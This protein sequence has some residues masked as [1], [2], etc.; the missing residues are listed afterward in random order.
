[1]FTLNWSHIFI[2][3]VAVILLYILTVFGV[4][5][6]TRRRQI[7]RIYKKSKPTKWHDY[8]DN[9]KTD[10]VKE[11]DYKL[12]KIKRN[13]KIHYVYKHNYNIS[14]DEIPDEAIEYEDDKIVGLMNP[15][16]FFTNL[17]FKQKAW[18]QNLL[19]NNNDKKIGYHETMY[20]HSI[21]DKSNQQGINK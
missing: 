12:V 13:N 18:L 1:M 15:F 6:I 21:N 9:Y 8:S 4:A 5:L 14:D 7:K 20:M 16:G 10:A 17:I 3:V 2:I 11:L 19:Q